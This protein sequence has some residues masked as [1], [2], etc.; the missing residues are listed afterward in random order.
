MMRHAPVPS[1]RSA[2]TTLDGGSLQQ[3]DEDN[4]PI[5]KGQEASILLLTLQVGGIREP[6]WHPSA[7]EI[8]L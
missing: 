3:A 6:H 4:F 1:R 2:P 7:W 5:L 8:N